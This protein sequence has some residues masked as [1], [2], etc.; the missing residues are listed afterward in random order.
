MTFRLQLQQAMIS[1]QL[2]LYSCNHELDWSNSSAAFE[3]KDEFFP[4]TSIFTYHNCSFL[5][6][7][8][9]QYC[10]CAHEEH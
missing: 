9:Q 1:M 7:I 2:S 8:V 3:A 10:S 4:E 5:H 6:N